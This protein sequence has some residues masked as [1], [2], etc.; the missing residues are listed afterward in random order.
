MSMTDTALKR[1]TS[2]RTWGA[3]A[4][5]VVLFLGALL[6]FVVLPVVQGG[7]AGIDPYTAICR[8]LGVLPGSPARD[9][10]ISDAAAQPV[11]R[12]SWSM[13]TF[14]ELYRADPA[15]GA[16]LAAERCIS[17]HAVEG[18]TPDPSIP[19]NLGQ[20][21]FALYKQLHDYKS[22][23]RVNE[24]MSPL[25]A[26]LDDKAIADLAAYYG[27][28]FRG[29]IDPNRTS[30]YFVGADIENI[31]RNGDFARGLP[32]CAACH[33]A[34]TGGPIETPTLTGQYASYLEAQ[35]TAFASG[36]RHNDIYHRMRSVASKL[37]AAEIKLLAIF[38]SGQ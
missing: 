16:G 31:I 2:W 4:V 3:L 5:L 29:A 37:T 28:L 27:A 32:P 26:D 19:R 36:Q 38:Y 6:G 35:L 24:I 33:G 25:V 22:G 17:C 11:T 12:V 20:S 1:D 10:P 8:A 13:E 9:T 23:A 21:R 14:G 30:P 15:A 7:A 18:N 34:R